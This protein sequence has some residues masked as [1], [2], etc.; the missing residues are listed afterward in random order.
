MASHCCDHL[1]PPLF[2]FWTSC[3]TQKDKVLTSCHHHGLLEA[4]VVFQLEFFHDGQEISGWFVVRRSSIAPKKTKTKTFTFIKFHKTVTKKCLDRKTCKKEC[5]SLRMLKFGFR[6]HKTL[7]D[8][9]KQRFFIC[10]KRCSCSV[11]HNP[12]TFQTYVVY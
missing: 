11:L 10:N 5:S 8:H 4:T 2:P 3:A 1:P 12:V 6:N 9:R 7:W